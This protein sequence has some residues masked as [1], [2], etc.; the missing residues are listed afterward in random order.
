MSDADANNRQAIEPL[1]RNLKNADAGVRFV[2]ARILGELGP[3]AAQGITILEQAVQDEDSRVRK[4]AADA[5]K[6]VLATH[7]Q[8]NQGNFQ[9]THQR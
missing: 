7:D 1:V 4:Y 2:T 8:M 6:K 9:K 3:K 5:L